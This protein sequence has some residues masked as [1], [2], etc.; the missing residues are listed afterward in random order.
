MQTP[1]QPA[2]G[3]TADS[4]PR[5]SILDTTPVTPGMSGYGAVEQTVAVAMA[6]DELGY[7]RLWVTEHHASEKIA[8]S[9]P[10][11][12]I[13][14]IAARTRHLRV[15]AGGVMLTNHQPLVTAEQFGTLEALYP[16]RID[17]GVGGSAGAPDTAT[18]YQQ[19]LGRTAR[20]GSNYPQYIDDLLG[21]VSAAF[22]A[23][24]P[25]AG[26][27]VSPRVGPVPV[28]VLGSSE[29]GAMLAAERGLPFAV[30][31]HLGLAAP[32]PLLELYRARFRPSATCAEPYTIVSVGA[33]CTAT[34]D[35]A[36][37]IAFDLGLTEVRRRT[38]AGGTAAPRSAAQSPDAP[39]T[40]HERGLVRNVLNRS[41]YVAGSPST[42]ADGLDRLAALT[43]ADE[44]ML[45]P[46]D[47]DGA[48]RVRTVRLIAGAYRRT[49][50]RTPAAGASR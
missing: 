43:G 18:V 25:Y 15:G 41:T 37:D 29:R 45:V 38:G 49:M 46:F 14:C 26:V 39:A 9:A 31:H 47:Q 36:E 40:L 3:E 48:G 16:G 20:S 27:R 12:L 6:A 30:A 21:F 1:H 24:H 5:L 34:D 19:A 4:R 23:G 44:M 42:V 35:E 13:A 28:F 32:G 10:A 17:L 7:H 2:V 8:S 11:V 50:L 33:L 22:P